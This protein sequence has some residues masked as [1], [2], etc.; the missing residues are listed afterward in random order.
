MTSLVHIMQNLAQSSSLPLYQQ[1]QRALREA[2]DKRIFGPD[3]TLSNRLSAVFETTKRQWEAEASTDTVLPETLAVKDAVGG[4]LGG[5]VT[6][7]RAVAV[8]LA[9]PSSSTVRVTS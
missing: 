5:A 1:L 4:V 3:E 7:T 8:S 9:P 6:V 2:I